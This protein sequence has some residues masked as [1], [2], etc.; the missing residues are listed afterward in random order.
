MQKKILNRDLFRTSVFARDG[1]KCII[2]NKNAILDNK[3][4][5]INL[6]AHHIIERRL[7]TDGGY[8]LDN[9]ASLCEVHH[10]EAEQTTLGCDEIRLKAGIENI[11]IPEHFYHDYSYDKWG[12]ILL[13]TGVKIRGEL[14]YDESVQKILK[15]GKVLDMFQKHIKYPRTYHLPWSNMLKDDRMLKDDSHFIGKRVIMSLKM[16]GENCLGPNTLIT[17]EDGTKTIKDICDSKYMGKI[18]S[19]NFESN[20]IEYE[21]IVAH[22]IADENDS[23]EWFEIE[24]ENGS[25]LEIT[26]EHYVYLPLLNCY[27]KVKDLQIDDEVKFLQ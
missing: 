14:F 21:K 18:L 4:E 7:F 2:C 22:N 15:Q 16:D 26:G 8:Y 24:L 5:P 23:D 12:N 1:Y 10:I 3:N 17:T 9:G 11:I 25:T 27:R 19:Y 20:E 6:D 13:P